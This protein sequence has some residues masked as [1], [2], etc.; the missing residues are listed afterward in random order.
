MPKKKVELEIGEELEEESV[1]VEDDDIDS[2]FSLD[3]DDIID[4]SE[5][6]EEDAFDEAFVKVGD[7]E[8]VIEGSI[9]SVEG[10]IG[11]LIVAIDE[12]VEHLTWLIYGK[13]GTG[14]TTLLSTVDGM[15]V[16]A[17][18]DGT[19]SIRDKVTGG[20]MKIR[21]DSWKK[22]EQVYWLLKEGRWADNGVYIQ[23]SQGQFHVKSLG[24]D[25]VTKLIEVC[26][27][28]VVLK[29]KEKDTSRDI[30][31]RTLRDW[32]DMGEK[33]KYWMNMFKELP[34]QKVWLCQESANAEDLESEEYTIYPAAN[35]SIRVY[36][37]SEADVIGRTYIK[38]T[39]PGKVQFRLSVAPNP[40][41]IT[42]DRTNQLGGIIPNPKLKTLYNKVFGE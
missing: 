22:M 9:A 3:E 33:L 31:K 20:A 30:I 24:F 14:K 8:D 35:K 1:D 37:Q 29:D 27:R 17:A 16:L 11:D 34:L 19:L 18:E 5:S 32:G 23:T 39:A 12:S 28:N 42:K 38:Q 36:L 7:E 6:T 40:T 41:Y 26:M 21:I 15:L 25:T 2:L 13:N 10:G 4:A